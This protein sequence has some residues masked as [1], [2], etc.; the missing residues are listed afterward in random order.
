[1]RF[2][3]IDFPKVALKTFLERLDED[4]KFMT[5]LNSF[6]LVKTFN[7]RKTNK[8]LTYFHLNPE[9]RKHILN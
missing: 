3:N 4:C 7:I 5:T 2:T 9:I 1:M 8:D 6:Q